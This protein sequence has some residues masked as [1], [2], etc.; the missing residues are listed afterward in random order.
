MSWPPIWA[1]TGSLCIRG[2]GL[3]RSLQSGSVRG[4]LSHDRL[5]PSGLR[6][7]GGP[8]LPADLPPPY[9]AAA[10]QLKADVEAYQSAIARIGANVGPPGIRTAL[11]FLEDGGEIWVW[12]V[13][14]CPLCSWTHRHSGGPKSGNAWRLLGGKAVHCR[15]GHPGGYELRDGDPM[16]SAAM[17]REA[18]VQIALNAPGAD[19]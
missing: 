10:R 18:G 19:V 12:R 2:C 8:P 1:S 6:T 5:S 9:G 7:P 16:R 17:M 11:A 3:A 13:Y 14:V 15:S 4:L